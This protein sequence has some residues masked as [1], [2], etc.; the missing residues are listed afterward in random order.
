[1]CVNKQGNTYDEITELKVFPISAPFNW[2]PLVEVQNI[3]YDEITL[4][5]LF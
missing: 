2:R 5:V 3:E 1:M 4:H